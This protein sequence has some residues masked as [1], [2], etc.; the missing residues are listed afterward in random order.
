VQKRLRRVK[1]LRSDGSQLG[2]RGAGLG[3]WIQIANPPLYLRKQIIVFVVSIHGGPIV[4]KLKAGNRPDDECH[5]RRR[6][7]ANCPGVK[8]VKQQT[9]TIRFAITD[10]GHAGLGFTTSLLSSTTKRGVH[11]TYVKPFA[12]QVRRVWPKVE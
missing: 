6:N 12:V 11:A 1:G 8:Q 2:P 7:A 4:R 3:R 9:F 10:P 5:G